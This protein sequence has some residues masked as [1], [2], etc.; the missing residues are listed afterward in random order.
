[1]P[2]AHPAVGISRFVRPAPSAWATTAP[3]V[4]RTCR[5]E[6]IPPNWAATSS[7]PGEA[8]RRKASPKEADGEANFVVGSKGLVVLMLL[9]VYQA[10]FVHRSLPVAEVM[11]VSLM[12]YILPFPL[13]GPS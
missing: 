9:T 7:L 12:S 8:R 1:M 3:R 4:S 10:S 5:S 2:E 13:T 6:R 11:P